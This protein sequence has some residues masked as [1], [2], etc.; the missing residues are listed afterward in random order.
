MNNKIIIILIITVITFVFEIFKYSF[1]YYKAT[2][3]TFALLVFS[4]F[5]SFMYRLF[6]NLYHKKTSF[7]YW[8]WRIYAIMLGLS[9]LGWIFFGNV[10]A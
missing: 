9:I 4:G 7:F 10:T 1:D 5:I 3:G 6:M 2:F 8:W